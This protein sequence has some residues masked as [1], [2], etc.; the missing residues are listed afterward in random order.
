MIKILY[1]KKVII[2]LALALMAMA[3]LSNCAQTGLI[4]K[5]RSISKE[6]LYHSQR[7]L[8]PEKPEKSQE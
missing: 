4:G 7:N 1:M 8:L 5:S 3:L 2:A 6:R